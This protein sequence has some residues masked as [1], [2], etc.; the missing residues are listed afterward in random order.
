M[1]TLLL[2]TLYEYS[3]L[4]YITVV[5]VCFVVTSGFVLG[6]FRLDVPVILRNSEEAYSTSFVSKKQMRQVKNPFGLEITNPDVASVTSG[7]SLTPN[8]LENCVLTYYWGCSV[9][10]LQEAL[11]H[12]LYC[13]IIKTPT[14][15]ENALFGEYLHKEQH[16]V[17]KHD[18]EEIFTQLP[19]DSQ[20]KDFGPLPRTRYP[21]VAFLTLS[22]EEDRES[23][24]IVSMLAVVH[25]P[26]RSYRLSCRIMYQYLL[27][28]QGQFYD[29]KQLFMSANDSQLQSTSASFS[30]DSTA[31]KDLL[32]KFG[33]SEEEVQ[34]DTA[35]DCVVCQNGKVN[36]V[37]LPCRHVCLCDGCLR[38]F[39]HCPICRQFVQESFPLFSQSSPTS[40]SSSP[41]QED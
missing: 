40:D 11:Q 16:V 28:A 29:L 27:T 1:P 4:F 18:K 15:L 23:Y 12:H 14:A 39:Q 38:F 34:E 22:D 21:L 25:V 35:K 20:L 24:D 3:P 41:I 13:F 30:H 32:E 19:P 37:L 7:I 33:L 6:W 31:D 5:F 10:K 8:C 17:Q 2:A 9:Q 36:W 26:D